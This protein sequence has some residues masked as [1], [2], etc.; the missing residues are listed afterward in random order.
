MRQRLGTALITA[1]GLVALVACGGGNSPAVDT[2]ASGFPMSVENCDRQLTFDAPPE[3]ILAIGGEAATLL[4]AAGA[5]DRISTFVRLAGEPLGEAESDLAR[6]PQISISGSG[7]ITREV[8]IGERPDLVVTFGL[9]QTSPDDLAAAGIPTLFVSGYCDGSGGPQSADTL[10]PLDGM[11]ADIGLYGQLLGTQAE[12]GSAV[13]G[14]RERVSAVQATVQAQGRSE[15]SAAA[16]FVTDAASALGGY[17]NRSTVHQ[18]MELL[19]LTNIFADVGE[20]YFQPT[21]EE[22]I[23]GNP[24]VLIA[25]YQASDSSDQGARDALTA[26][27]EIA[28]IPAIVN[29][30]VVVLDF[31]YA[32]HG[33][34]AVD[35]LETLADQLAALR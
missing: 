6:R 17:G 32:G 8:I 18:Q 27:P 14:L 34:L 29:K 7:D 20:R 2:G 28:Q 9:N 12:A 15:S 33:I 10:S 22:L 19:S 31:F 24:E 21:V 16:L 35:G 30:D 5:T 11:Y 26:R 13:A 25:L 23:D 4:W 3:R 1:L